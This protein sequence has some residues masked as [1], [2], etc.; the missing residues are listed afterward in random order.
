MLFQLAG[1]LHHSGLDPAALQAPG[2]T[3]HQ[4]RG[5]LALALLVE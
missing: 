2:E 5:G 4:L 1:P 3:A